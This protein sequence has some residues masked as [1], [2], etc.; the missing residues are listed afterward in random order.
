MEIKSYTKIILW[1][2]KLFRCVAKL[3][4]NHRLYYESVNQTIKWYTL[5]YNKNIIILLKFFLSIKTSMI[6]RM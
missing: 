5:L 3:L 1:K 2:R 6:K 4:L